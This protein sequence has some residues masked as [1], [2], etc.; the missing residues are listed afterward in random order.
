LVTGIANAHM[1]SIPMVIITGQV[2]RAAIGSDA[3]QETD[4][5]GITDISF[6]ILILYTL[7]LAH[8]R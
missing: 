7:L 1:D 4:I 8:H 3:F 2:S 6:Q 5:Y